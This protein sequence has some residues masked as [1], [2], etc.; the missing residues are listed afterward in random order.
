MDRC[1]PLRHHARRRRAGGGPGADPGLHRAERRAPARLRERLPAGGQPGGHRPHEPRAQPAGPSSS[2]RPA[3]GSRSQYSVERLR[4]YG[5]DVSTPSLRRLLVA[6]GGRRRDDDRAV[7]APARQ[8]GGRLPLAARLRGRRG[9]LQRLL[10][11]PGDVSGQVVYANYGLPEDYAELERLGVDVRGKIVLVRYGGSF[12]GVKAQQA[13]LRGAKGVLIYSDPADDGF[14][15]RRRLPGGP[16]AAGGRDPARLDPVHLQLPGRPAHAGRRRRSPA[17]GGSRPR[18]PATC[19]G[20][21]PRRSPTARRSRCWRTSAGPR[22]RSRSRAGSPTTATTSGRAAPRSGSTSTS[23]TSRCRSATCWPR[24]AARRKPDEKVVI[25]AHYDG[26]TYGTSDNTSGWTTIMEIGRSLGRLLDRGWRPE[27]TI[28]LAGWDG[29]EYG[30]LGSTEW[31]EQFQR[32]LARDAVAYA[33]LDGAG[34]TSFGA[35]GVP[36]LDDALVEVTQGG[37]RP[38]HR[39]AGLRHVAGRRARR[40]RSTGS[41]A[42]R[43]TPRSSTT[44]A[45][46]RSR[47]ASPRRRAAAPTTRPTTTRYNMERYLDPGL[48]RARRL[49]ARDGRD[50]AAAGERRRAAVP[51]LGLRGRGAGYVEELQQVQAETRG[52]AQVDLDIL[53]EAAEAW[54][55]AAAALEARADALLAAGDTESRAGAA[56]RSRRINAR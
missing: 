18:R 14:T 30:L 36:Q 56:A 20:S 48:P 39:A 35:A 33:N 49:G 11:R 32:D 10:A 26:W 5:L 12:R 43:T 9:R 13:E 7:H 17:R 8:Q 4:S 29:E 55:A 51:V 27:R 16:V 25:G 53:L 42:A 23:P 19:R 41:A 38:A 21:R 6:A 46:R 22:R 34:G 3:C 52:A 50:R 54:G 44:S 15:A 2:P 31:V 24:S 37:R 45:C 47:P 1:R 28:V 40:R